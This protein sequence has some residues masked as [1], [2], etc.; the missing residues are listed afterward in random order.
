MRL[1]P[2]HLGAERRII[3]QA[4]GKARALIGGEGAQHVFGGRVVELF[5]HA[6]SRHAF[7]SRTLRCSS[8]LIVPTGRPNFSASSSR[9]NPEQ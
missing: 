7:S 1:Q 3:T 2:A 5:A 9:E 8:V 6:L 4:L